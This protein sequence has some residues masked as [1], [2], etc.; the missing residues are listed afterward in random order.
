MPA[1]GDRNRDLKTNIGCNI[2]DYPEEDGIDKRQG[3]TMSW[4]SRIAVIAAREAMQQSGLVHGEPIP[5]APAALS[6]S[7]PSAPM[8]WTKAMSIFFSKEKAHQLFTVPKVMPSGPA[9]HVSIALGLRGPVF[10]CQFGLRVGQSC[11]CLR[12]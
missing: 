1:A 10:G 12:R 2:I 9:S 6:A 5:T 11:L 4:I 8:R 3:M 7:A